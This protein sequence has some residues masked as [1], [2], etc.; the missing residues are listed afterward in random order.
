MSDKEV[1]RFNVLFEE[2]RSN[3]MALVEGHGVLV[4]GQRGLAAGQAETN[5][6]LDRIEHR[7]TNVDDRLTKVEH[8]LDLNGAPS[9]KR[10]KSK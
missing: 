3:V 5:R 6:R 9:R 2:M 8:H 7:L 4:E 10:R 1:A